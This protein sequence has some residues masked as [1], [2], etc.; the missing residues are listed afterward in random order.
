MCL[1]VLYAYVTMCTVQAAKQNKLDYYY[2][3]Y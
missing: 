3:Y 1:Y 2:Y